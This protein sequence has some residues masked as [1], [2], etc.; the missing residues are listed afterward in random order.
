MP[1][2]A[3]QLSAGLRPAARNKNDKTNP[4]S[5]NS[6]VHTRNGSEADAGTR[7][8][9]LIQDTNGNQIFFR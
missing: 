9:T 6:F 5:P 3:A 7:Y 4:I 1:I 8:P 2:T